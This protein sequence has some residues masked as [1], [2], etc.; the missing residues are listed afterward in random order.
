SSVFY[1]QDNATFNDTS[2]VH[3]ITVAANVSP[4]STHV[5]T[6]G[7]YVFAGPGGIVGGSLTVDGPGIVGLANAGNS[8]AG[9]PQV[10]AGT[11]KISGNA[12][13][14]V[15]SITVAGGA[16]LV[17]ASSTSLSSPLTLAGDGPD[18]HGALLIGGGHTVQ[19]L[20]NVALNGSATI[21]V[22]AA[23]SGD[24]SG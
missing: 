17:V 16:A 20:G 8:Y 11:V 12:S 24:L 7:T 10:A 21:G 6:A 1:D 23:A 4:G 9:P 14:M 2:V 13:A 19:L 18:G 3:N 15:S 5:T 22:E